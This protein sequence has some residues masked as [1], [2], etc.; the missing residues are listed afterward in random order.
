MYLDNIQKILCSLQSVSAAVNQ[1]TP[2]VYG[3]FITD[4]IDT[5][6]YIRGKPLGPRDPP[7]SAV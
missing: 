5:H 6:R 3:G 7:L 2:G 4:Y 1:N